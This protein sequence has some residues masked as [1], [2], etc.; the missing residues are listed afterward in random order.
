[1]NSY[2]NLLIERA[3]TM[4]FILH[5]FIWQRRYG[6]ELS[7]R[8][9]LGF[10]YRAGVFYPNGARYGQHHDDFPS[11]FD[12]MA[13]LGLSLLSIESLFCYQ[14]YASCRTFIDT[15]GGIFNFP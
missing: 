2:D 15:N 11:F 13:A 1:M 14:K 8:H 9:K 10:G 6:D 12:Q 7:I 4:D 3:K 5:W